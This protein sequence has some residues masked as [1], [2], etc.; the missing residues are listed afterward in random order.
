MSVIAL[1]RK[2]Y[3][4]VKTATDNIL[5]TSNQVQFR[6]HSFFSDEFREFLANYVTNQSVPNVCNIKLICNQPEA[7]MW[8]ENTWASLIEKKSVVTTVNS[9]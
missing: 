7:E 9:C 1:A 3:H 5:V 2:Q 8:L 6:R 4:I